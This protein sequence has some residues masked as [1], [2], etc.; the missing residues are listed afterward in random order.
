LAELWRLQLQITLDRSRLQLQQL[1]RNRRIECNTKQAF[2]LS[3]D[4][5]ATHLTPS[6][7]GTWSLREE[8]VIL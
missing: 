7:S 8:P 6:W 3:Q 1:R 4:R 2:F 5:T